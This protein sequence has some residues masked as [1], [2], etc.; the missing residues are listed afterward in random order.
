[1]A[2]VSAT[3]GAAP[4]L[5]EV[6]DAVADAGRAI[7]A[8][9]AAGPLSRAHLR[10]GVANASGDN[11]TA[12][13]MLAHA[14]M[15][16]R[17]QACPAVGLLLSEEGPE[18][19]AGQPDGEFAVC[20]DPLDGSSNVESSMPTG[21]IFSVFRI[22]DRGPDGL[23]TGASL[24]QRGDKMEAAGYVLFSSA[25]LLAATL[26]VGC[27]VEGFA[28]DPSTARFVPT[29]RV[30]IPAEPARI[31]SANAGRSSLWGLEASA[32]L[33]ATTAAEKPYTFRYTGAMVAD[34][35][36]VLTNGGIFLYPAD[37]DHPAGKLRVLY[38]CFPLAML[39][40]AAGGA[41]LC[42]VPS[43]AGSG[44]LLELVPERPHQRTPVVLGCKRDV[45][46]YAE[47]GAGARAQA[48]ALAAAEAPAPCPTVVAAVVSDF[49]P[50][51]AD[52]GELEVKRGQL[53]KTVTTFSDPAWL[54]VTL[55]TGER[56]AVPAK[57]V[58]L[59][60]DGIATVT[61]RG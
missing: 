39:V 48:G 53:V 3:L 32:F 46:L 60:R 56:G 34:V 10:T 36:R 38:E 5:G 23:A 15:V 29:G 22:V 4:R 37:R 40:E 19:I 58:A 1:M 52:S 11:Q 7:A 50:G 57:S 54:Q 12:L 55:V 17:L 33:Q 30:T 28:L 49:Q 35:H 26:G 13:D 59:L 47:L 20:F 9:V 2:D 6:L 51:D 41:A 18:P 31:V 27:G 8:L 14:A 42:A 21:M 24:L 43:A 44:R 45:A 25:T 16:E 61:V